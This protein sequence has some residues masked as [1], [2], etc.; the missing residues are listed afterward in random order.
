V[1]GLND[2]K[3]YYYLWV[4]DSLIND[5]DKAGALRDALLTHENPPIVEGKDFTFVNNAIAYVQNNLVVPE[6]A[7]IAMIAIVCCVCTSFASRS[8]FVR[9]S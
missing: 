4:I 5:G 9:W 3:N 7:S 8:R 1:P 6:P 2:S